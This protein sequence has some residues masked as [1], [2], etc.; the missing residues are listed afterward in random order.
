MK[1]VCIVTNYRNT[2]NYGAIL[3]AYA[4][5][6]QINDMGFYCETL[7]FYSER[8]NGNKLK[9]YLKRIK[10]G[11]IIYLFSDVK[12]DIGKMIVRK[13]MQIRRRS[14]DEFRYSIPHTKLYENDEL[15]KLQYDYDGF[16]C[17]SDQIW[18]PTYEGNLIETYWLGN[19]LNSTMKASYAASIG[20]DKLSHLNEKKAKEYLESF[21]FVSVREKSA[22]DYLSSICN[23]QVYRVIDP[24]FL[25]NI[26][27]WRKIEN[28][29][30]INDRYILVYMIYGSSHLYKKIKEFAKKNKYKIVV[31]PYMAYYYRIYEQFFGDYK[32]Y[33]A[34][35]GDFLSLIDNAEFV[36]TDS[37][38]ATAFS[39]IFHKK[40]AVATTNSKAISRINNLLDICDL[41]QNL[42]IKPYDINLVSI[43]DNTVNWSEVNERIKREVFDSKEYLKTTLLSI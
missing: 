18:R 22:Q 20:I 15:H 32:I 12:R 4:L 42:L 10:K 2:G 7:N 28:K 9:R 26:N 29:T 14:L 35:P 5:N 27:E 21:S 40:F 1:R 11:E 41:R 43:M 13:K 34:T 19:I 38:H 16:V 6:K 3:Q 31:F 24:V 8:Q 17:G 36:I 30:K 23:K 33:D 39:I 25:L 37:F